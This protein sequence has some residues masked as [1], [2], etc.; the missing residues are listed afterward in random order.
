[1][2]HSAYNARF[3]AS[4]RQCLRV[5]LLVLAVGTGLAT[6]SHAGA[7]APAERRAVEGGAVLGQRFVRKTG[8]MLDFELV[9]SFAG[10]FKGA[11]FRTNRFGMRDKE[12]VLKPPANTYRIALIGS[13][14][15]MG[16]GVSG[17]Q[18]FE[19]LLEDRLS[20]EGPGVPRRHYEVLNLAVGGYNNLQYVVV[21][22]RKV[23]QFAPRAVLLVMHGIEGIRMTGYVI[24]LVHNSVPISEPYL[25]QKL[26]AAGIRA[27][28][29]EPEIRRRLA[30][31]SNE[32]LKWSYQRMAQLCRE[33]GVYLV[34]VAF[35][36]ARE[37]NGGT[38][39]LAAISALASEAGIPVVS[40]AGVYGTH[41]VDSV[42]LS[43]RDGHLNVFG[44]QL[45][46]DR[47][48]QVL[49]QNDA[50]TLR[51]DQPSRR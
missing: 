35:P 44:H 45:I 33:H 30:P 2:S 42:S 22:G 48:Y 29:E 50:R 28:M 43:P 18:T 39:R 26:E 10:R 38:E 5:S 8:D 25:R 51:L 31:I 6:G 49:R 20:R 23:F 46:A 17:E 21:M 15:A 14:F 24:S 32:L 36:L 13:S 9:P 16:G 41:P 12:Y 11:P 47:L 7:Q 19:N 40:L 1:M 27:G 4:I 3:P 37:T 34:G